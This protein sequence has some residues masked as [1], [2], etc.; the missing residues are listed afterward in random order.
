MQ[1]SFLG[2]VKDFQSLWLLC[3]P[4][5]LPLTAR[6]Q[7][8]GRNGS[9]L[10]LGWQRPQALSHG[11]ER[12]A[13]IGGISSRQGH[14]VTVKPSTWGAW[15]PEAT[16]WSLPCHA[17]GSSM[18]HNSLPTSSPCTALSLP[19]I[20]TVRER[21]HARFRLVFRAHVY[22]QVPHDFL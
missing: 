21:I 7:S 15:S 22:P 13:V 5:T 17:S 8:K 6:E 19:R 4:Y 12:T 11:M 9:T 16:R 1:S 14:T 10:L 2:Q 20:L 3:W 18:S